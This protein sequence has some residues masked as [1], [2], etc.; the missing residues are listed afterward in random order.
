MASLASSRRRHPLVVLAPFVLLA[1]L[2]ACTDLLAMRR[3]SQLRAETENLVADM[4][5]D[6]E[7]VSR[8]H[9]DLD[10]INLLT[11]RHIFETD[12]SAMEA[13]DAQIA[14]NRAD[15]TVA[16][17]VYRSL[18]MLPEERVEWE[19]L[20]AE[21]RYIEPRLDAL[22]ALSRRN[23]NFEAQQDVVALGDA[24]ARAYGHL[25][26]LV[27]INHRSADETVARVGG[28]Q[29]ASSSGLQLLALAG[30]G[31]SV[32]LGLVM[33]H[34]LQRR[35]LQQRRYAEMLEQSNRELDAF[36][37]RVAH[38][39]RGPLT[40]ASLA[41]TRLG[42]QSPSPEQQKTLG[43]LERSFG[44]MDAIIQDLLAISRVQAGESVG[45]C[46]PAAAAEQLREEL[47]PRAEGSDVSLV[48][49]VHHASVHCSEGLFRQVIWNLADNAMKY[50]RPEIHSRVEICGRAA[51]DRYELSVQDNGVGMSPEEAHKA[52]DAFYRAEGRKGQPGTGLGLSIVKRVVEANGGSVSV[53]SEPGSGSKFVTRL[54]L[55]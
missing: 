7:L 10:R 20:T 48:I 35:E 31:L 50:R 40:T 44:R 28:L 55:A 32:I 22:L 23:E 26:T 9:R 13:L 29:R 41:A 43:T 54:P 21:I 51:D 37:A 4:L 16:A 6:I 36:A 42:M 45:V 5:T 47:A 53:T 46:D 12:R 17:A 2:I 24:F 27:H 39:L 18:P 52:F 30:I 11:D 3:V 34:A 33:T 25:S 14:L 8:M 38:D 49:D 15:F 1:A 19:G